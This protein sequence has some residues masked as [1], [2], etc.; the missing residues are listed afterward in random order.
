[1]KRAKL[2]SIT[3]WKCSGPIAQKSLVCG[4]VAVMVRAKIS[5][6]NK[7]IENVGKTA[8]IYS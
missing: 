8:T 6:E 4:L 3:Q 2:F 1:M 5:G 7:K